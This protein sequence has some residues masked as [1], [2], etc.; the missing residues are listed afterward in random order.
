MI[1]WY[2]IFKNLISYL[3]DSIIIQVGYESLNTNIKKWKN[4]NLK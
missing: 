3:D 1:A 2:W 4:N